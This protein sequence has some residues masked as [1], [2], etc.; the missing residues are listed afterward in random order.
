MLQIKAKSCLFCR[1][2]QSDFQNSDGLVSGPLLVSGPV[3]GGL[4]P[5][6]KTFLLFLLSV[7]ENRRFCP[8]GPAC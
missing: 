7:Q 6:L 3:L 1:V 8:S 4:K 2:A 5:D